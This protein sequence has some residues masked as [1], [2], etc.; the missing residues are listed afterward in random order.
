MSIVFAGLGRHLQSGETHPFDVFQTA[1]TTYQVRLFRWLVVARLPPNP[2]FQVRLCLDSSAIVRSFYSNG[3]TASSTLTRSYPQ[4]PHQLFV[5]AHVS[6][7]T[8]CWDWT[9]LQGSTHT[10]SRKRR[11]CLSGCLYCHCELPFSF[12]R[13]AS[14][15][16]TFRKTK[17]SLGSL[18]ISCYIWQQSL[19]GHWYLRD[20]RAAPFVPRS[21]YYHYYYY[22]YNYNNSYYYYYYY[23]AVCFTTLCLFPLPVFRQIYQMSPVII[24]RVTV[25]KFQSPLTPHFP[26]TQW[27]HS[28]QHLMILFHVF[29]WFPRVSS[30]NRF[31][32][33]SLPPLPFPPPVRILCLH[34]HQST[35]G[36]T[37]CWSKQVSSFRTKQYAFRWW[38]SMRPPF[39]LALLTFHSIVTSHLCKKKCWKCQSAWWTEVYLCLPQFGGRGIR[40][41]MSMEGEGGDK[42]TEMWFWRTKKV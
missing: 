6:C 32:R 14:R 15:W 3:W 24:L 29:V 5:T 11:V 18:L 42:Y 12:C 30:F 20:C 9:R 8:S 21:F 22:Y 19:M 23:Y 2:T 37:A 33:S 4:L 16:K 25:G 28:S 10:T 38:K 17:M 26:W 7:L 1:F 36:E 40:A 35:L 34:H 39:T 41:M 13:C 27:C 31:S